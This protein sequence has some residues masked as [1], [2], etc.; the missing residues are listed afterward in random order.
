MKTYVSGDLSMAIEYAKKIL[1]KNE[2]NISALWTMAECSRLEGNIKKAISYGQKAYLIDPK[3]FDTLQLLSE[4]YFDKKDY[5]HAYEYTCRAISVSEEIDEELQPY[6]EKIKQGISS[7]KV[8]F[9]PVR[10]V[11]QAMDIEQNNVREWI[12]WALQFKAWYEFSQLPG[13]SEETH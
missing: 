9:A 8:T 10:A 13:K 11:Q 4:V 12:A 5:K 2:K 1:V 3:H 7:S 6:I